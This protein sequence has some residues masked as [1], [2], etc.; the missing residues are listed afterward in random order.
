MTFN[1][2]LRTLEEKLIPLVTRMKPKTL[3]AN[4]LI[5]PQLAPTT[6]WVQPCNKRSPS[7]K[8][9]KRP[10]NGSNAILKV[11]LLPAEEKR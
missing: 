3:S 1:E 8:S 11:I 6:M 9:G 7:S 4:S 5:T 10:W 2:S